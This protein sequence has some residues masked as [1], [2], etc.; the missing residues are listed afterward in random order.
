MD[1]EE[2]KSIW[3]V[4]IEELFSNVRPYSSEFRNDSDNGPI[5]LK[6]GV[7]AVIASMK[8]GKA[9]GEYG[10]DV[11]VIQALGDFAV[12]QMTSLFQKMCETG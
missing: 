5:I 3:N 12:D 11:E 1:V 2:V 9:V 7:K 10:I 8:R 6:D 4:Y